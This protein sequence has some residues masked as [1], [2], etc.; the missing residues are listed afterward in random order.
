MKD[1]I[2][3][4]GFFRTEDSY[5]PSSITF[6]KCI[7]CIYYSLNVKINEQIYSTEWSSGST[8]PSGLWNISEAIK[9][10]AR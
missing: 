4:N 9:T 5:L 2:I 6:Q 1:L 3:G 10:A 8:V 7:D